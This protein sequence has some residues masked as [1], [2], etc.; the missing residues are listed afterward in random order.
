MTTISNTD[1][2]KYVQWIEDGITKD[3]INYYD[4]NEFQ[5]IRCIGFGAYGRV[6]RTT[7]ESSDTVVALKSF[8]FNNC[9]MK[10]IVNE[11]MLLNKVNLHKNIIQFF[12]ITKWTK[13]N[14][15]NINSDYL[16]ILEYADSD[17]LRNYLKKN[18]NGLDWDIKLQF[19]VQ[20]ASAVTFMHKKDII[21]RDLHS[22]NILIHQNMI[23]IADFGLSRRIAEVSN[24]KNVIGML[25]YIDPQLLNNKTD[26]DKKYKANKKSDVYS[27]GVLLWEI[28]SG[29]IPF[30][31][32]DTFHQQPK[33]MVEI[34]SGK[35][36]APVAGTPIDYLN[37][38]KKC[39]EDNSDDRPNIQQVLSDL[40]LINMNTNEMEICENTFE[41]DIAHNSNSVDNNSDSSIHYSLQ[42]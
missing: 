10:E 28:S 35:R 29:L 31:S 13:N 37:I 20:I 34:L 24:K 23:K 5:E 4:Y 26:D 22:K 18:F 40:K 36:E 39:W 2:D 27:V 25:P 3:Y 9:V 12:G 30:E 42:I 32:Y 11:I 21:H 17:T 14:E 15:N 6:Y 41:N 1:T 38:Y 33:L 16:L 8:E 7:W 19:A